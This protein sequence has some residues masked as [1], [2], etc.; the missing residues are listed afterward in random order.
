MA[1]TE[2]SRARQVLL[3]GGLCLGP[4]TFGLLST[5]VVPLVPMAS[6]H[7]GI[8]AATANLIV[9]V[10][11]IAGTV[12]IPLLARLGDR[13]GRRHVLLL[14]LGLLLSGCVLA[15]AT[16]NVAAL[17][18]ARFLQ[19]PGVASAPLGFAVVAD[20]I[21]VRRRTFGIGIVSAAA[22]VGGGF[23]APMGGLIVAGT[24]SIQAVFWVLTGIALAAF[25]ATW[26]TVPATRSATSGDGDV[27]GG[28]LLT[29]ALVGILVALAEGGSW[30][31]GS[32]ATLAFAGVGLVSGG[33]WIAQGYLAAHPLVDMRVF[34]SWP[35]LSTNVG[36]IALG[37]GQLSMLLSFVAISQRD[38]ASGYG[39]GLGI[40]AA[41]LIIVPCSLVQAASSALLPRVASRIGLR[42]S[43]MGG[44]IVAG[45]SLVLLAVW[46]D[47]AWA[48]VIGS[49]LCTAGT[50]A[51]MS[52]SPAYIVTV[53]VPPERG[54]AT[55]M[56]FICRTIG[57]ALGTAIVAATATAAT[58]PG[59]AVPGL[60][61]YQ[62]A[63]VLA[64]VASL[65]SAALIGY[66]RRRTP[67]AAGTLL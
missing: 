51:S 45:L 28:A 24:G 32:P 15:A 41:T 49:C 52:A 12:S 17:L 30:G 3:L 61:G 58:P 64:A 39:L 6:T 10:T 5:A 18:V 40:L 66:A 42:R 67:A 50:G 37:V 33:L 29:M 54:V 36:A 53:V 11:L 43:L 65:G 47:N 2:L 14:S 25:L 19:G 22:S 27:V 31:W 7:Y 4:L 57:Q 20:L 26:L 38:P 48:L 44:S 16:D 55:G 46:N 63:L 23:G 35:V 1:T 13:Y 21:P 59:S 34:L 62:V 56:N 8:S 9:T 60:G